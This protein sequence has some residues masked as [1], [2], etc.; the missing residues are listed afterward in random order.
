MFRLFPAAIFLLILSSFTLTGC[1]DSINKPVSVVTFSNDGKMAIAG[2]ED[3]FVRTLVQ[4]PEIKVTE[5]NI[6]QGNIRNVVTL[7]APEQVAV[8]ADKSTSIFIVDLKTKKVEKEIKR[9]GGKI[10]HLVSTSNDKLILCDK[11]WVIEVWELSGTKCSQS[12]N[13]HE[14]VSSM[15]ISTDDSTLAVAAGKRV[16][17]FDGHTLNK[18]NE[19]RFWRKVHQVGFSANGQHLVTITDWKFVVYDMATKKIIKIRENEE[20]HFISPAK[21]EQVVFARKYG[22]DYFYYGNISEG[23]LIKSACPPEEKVVAAISPKGKLFAIGNKDGLQVKKVPSYSIFE[24]LLAKTPKIDPNTPAKLKINAY[25]MGTKIAISNTKPFISKG[26]PKELELKAGKVEIKCSRDGCL[27]EER[28]ITARPGQA[29]ELEFDLRAKNLVITPYAKRPQKAPIKSF[30]QPKRPK[31]IHAQSFPLLFLGP[32]MKHR[33]HRLGFTAVGHPIVAVTTE[34]GTNIFNVVASL[35]SIRVGAIIHK[36]KDL[37]AVLIHEYLAPNRT[38]RTSL[39]LAIASHRSFH[40]IAAFYNENHIEIVEIPQVGKG[41]KKLPAD[42]TLGKIP[43]E[44]TKYKSYHIKESLLSPYAGYFAI[45]STEG[46]FS[47]YNCKTG[48]KVFERQ[49]SKSKELSFCFSPSGKQIVLSDAV[50]IWVYSAQD[51]NQIHLSKGQFPAAIALNNRWLCYKQHNGDL[52]IDNLKNNLKIAQLGHKDLI[53]LSVGFTKEN[54]ALYAATRNDTVEVWN[55]KD[56]SH[57]CSI[58]VPNMYKS[59]KVGNG[60]PF[61]IWTNTRPAMPTVVFDEG[62]T[63]SERENFERSVRIKPRAYGVLSLSNYGLAN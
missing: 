27:P 38:S 11:N 48:K 1:E 10:L 9:S 18:L 55:P 35:A 39:P 31:G 13:I 54:S 40:A 53:F 32:G 20:H 28:T 63:K 34:K 14:K 25:P 57:K 29:L 56:W 30:M 36:P 61:A 4:K 42:K 58:D 17:F 51:G 46:W 59:V 19:I 45:S 24:G 50:H 49:Y 23:E 47:W 37:S 8:T 33:Q 6:G 7:T 60:V 2:C 41:V 3:G 44:S 26:K 12:V 21:S 15:A 22:G 43:L 62:L 5:I 52:A 16:I